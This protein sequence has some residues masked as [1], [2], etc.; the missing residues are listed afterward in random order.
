MAPRLHDDQVE[1][2]VELARALV[3]DQA[4][5]F[6]ALPLRRVA[7]GGTDNAV[8]RLGNELALR[9]PLIPGAVDG[10][11]KELRWLPVLAPHISLEIPEVVTTGEPTGTY[12]FPWA[13]VRW[14]DGEDALVAPFSSMGEAA[15]D[16][17]QFVRE[18]QSIDPSEVAPPGSDGF[19]RG[20]PLAGRDDVFRSF[21]RQ[22]EGLLD[23]RRVEEIWEDALSAPEWDGARYGCTQ[24]CSRPTCWFAT[25]GSPGA[26]L[27]R[28]G[29]R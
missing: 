4:P 6:V 23:V 18:L 27:R 11:R 19:S 29:Q 22:C 15:H 2:D 24:T 12:P 25:A 26:R 20:L 1:I 3:A 7:S 10:L 14:L 5:E 9:M 8:F 28:D 17:G 21:L 16:L 13:V